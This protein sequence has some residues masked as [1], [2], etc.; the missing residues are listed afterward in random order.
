MKN[1]SFYLASI[2]SFFLVSCKST[3]T[4]YQ[5]YETSPVNKDVKTQNGVLQY[6]DDRCAIRYHFWAE[7]GTSA[8]SFFN[9]TDKIIYIDL[10]KCF[11]CKK[12]DATDLY[13]GLSFGKA[14]TYSSSAT[15]TTSFSYTKP[16]SVVSIPPHKWKQIPALEIVDKIYYDCDLEAYPKTSSL[17]ISFDA[18]NSPICF[19]NYITYNVGDNKT[20]FTVE[21]KFYVSKITNYAAPEIVEYRERSKPCKNLEKIPRFANRNEYGV[22]LYDKFIKE[23]IVDLARSFYLTNTVSSSKRMYNA[24]IGCHYQSLYDAYVIE[25]IGTLTNSSKVAKTPM[26]STS[27]AATNT[28][29]RNT[30]SDVENAVSN[31]ALRTVVIQGNE[32]GRVYVDG[33]FVSTGTKPIYNV[34]KNG[35]IHIEIREEGFV[36]KTFKVEMHE[37]GPTIVKNNSVKLTTLASFDGGQEALRQFISDNLRYPEVAYRKKIGGEVEIGCVID[38]KGKV[39]NVEVVQGVEKTLD[40]E[41]LIIARSMPNWKPATLNGENVDSFVIIPVVFSA[42]Q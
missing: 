4:F 23:E 6:E 35:V 26:V 7:H 5:V 24:Y 38:A 1:L 8:F 36:N 12:D 21:N 32:N 19:S 40:E 17:S 22:Q 25:K 41:A 37:S 30:P 14:T 28:V 33:K 18:G 20:D 34:K 2:A 39:K 9:K 31:S 10:T 16:L 27:K 13:H 42:G 3:Y 29:E 11:F 15:T